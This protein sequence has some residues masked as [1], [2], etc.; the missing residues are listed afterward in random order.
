[1]LPVRSL[2]I[3]TRISMEPQLMITLIT[4]R[5]RIIRKLTLRTIMGTDI[6]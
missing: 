2:F 4:M 1:M 6:N 3:L 5:N